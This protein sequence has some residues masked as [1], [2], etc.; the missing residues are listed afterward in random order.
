[1]KEI[2]LISSDG[3]RDSINLDFYAETKEECIELVLQDFKDVYSDVI[4]ESC[5]FINDRDIQ[6]LYYDDWDDEKVY[7][8]SKTYHLFKI[9]K[10]EK[11]L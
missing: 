2:Y 3:H 4:I 10:H 5:E 1:M 7:K 6:I 9:K 11:E 8:E